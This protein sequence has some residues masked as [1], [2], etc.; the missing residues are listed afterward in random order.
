MICK[1]CGKE[2]HQTAFPVRG[3]KVDGSPS[4]R[5]SCRSCWNA[6]RRERESPRRFSEPE[7]SSEPDLDS[8]VKDLVELSGKSPEILSTITKEEFTHYI[9]YTESFSFTTVKQKALEYL[10][11]IGVGNPSSI[12]VP[13]T[14]KVLV[15]GDTYGQHTRTGM[16]NL[17]KNICN[18]YSVD[19]IVAVGRQLDENNTISHCFK[20]LNVPITFVATA[21]EIST[22]H[23]IKEPDWTICRDSVEVGDVTI[24]NQEQVT[25]YVKKAIYSIDQILFPNN[26]IVNCTRQEYGVRSSGDYTTFVASPGAL[27]DAFVPKVRNKLMIKNGLRTVEVFSSSF[28]KYR[29]AEE[30]KH[31]WQQGCIL[32]NNA[33][34]LFLSIKKVDGKYTTAF[35]GTVITE[36]KVIHNTPVTVV[37]SD[38]HAPHH[39]HESF[40]VFLEYCSRRPITELVLNGDISDMEAVNPHILSRGEPTKTTV[41]ENILS[42]E[43]IIESVAG[44]VG[45]DTSIT[46]VTG[47]HSDFLQRWTNKNPQFESLFHSIITSILDKHYVT[48]VPVNN[49]IKCGHETYVLHGNTYVSSSGSTNTER[50]ARSFNQSIIGHS[51]STNLRFGCLRTGCLCKRDQGYNSPYG[52]WDRSFGVITSYSGTDF[53]SP[54]FIVLDQ[55]VTGNEII[56]GTG[57]HEVILN[58]TEV[59]I[60]G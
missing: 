43:S 50:V 58:K 10:D 24:R 56:V 53:V 12:A 37:A 14:R 9:G 22:L 57:D 30:D 55:I 36:D 34:P 1:T 60:W 29:K 7:V 20:D 25:P 26:T 59:T 45:D 4:Y 3:Q 32:L 51:H 52:N 33:M 35:D 8:L 27:A 40:E 23:K 41:S 42:F 18:E 54:L 19:M 11:S 39:D 38:I 6:I 44:V 31:L 5:S 48:L 2:M 21:D 15:I 28:K 46:Y 13:Y 17:I 47:N 49:N 16:F